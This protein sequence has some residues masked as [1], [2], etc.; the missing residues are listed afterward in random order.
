MPGPE[1]LTVRAHA[2]ARA[3]LLGN[4]SDGYH[5]RTISFTFR[6][7]GASVTCR[8]SERLVIVP[9]ASDRLEYDSIDD[10]LED[11]RV[12]GYYGGIR[13][14]KAGIKRFHQHFAD[15]SHPLPGREF[16]VE[17]DTDIPV[18]VGLAGSSAIVTAL[19]R[20]LMEFHGVTIDLPRL[21]NAVLAT[22]TEELG[23][24]AGLQDRVAQA[25]EGLVSMDFARERMERDGHGAYERLD[26]GCLPPLFIAFH[27]NLAE[28]TEV[29]HTDLRE[30]HRRGEPEVFAAIDE[31]AD[32]ARR[33]RDL[34]AAR[35]GEKI[36]PLMNANF[37]IRDRLGLVSDANRRMVAIGRDLG[38][39]VKFAGSGGAVVGAFDG[40]PD[41]LRRLRDAYADFGAT[42]I[43]PEI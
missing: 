18:R 31:L 8:D 15:M 19:F 3:G 5:G 9:R 39:A 37:A 34:I 40:D 26:P 20:A 24:A 41:L 10:L 27:P 4:P 17:Y 43:T 22:E 25:Y 14:I 2:Y 42:L 1:A 11:V 16:T 13:L 6:N 29:P 21:P 32:L 12:H 33:G 7:F 30:R 36:G 35:R 28:G 23:I 38:A